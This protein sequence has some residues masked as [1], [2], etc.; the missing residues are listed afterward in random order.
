M[1]S[2]MKSES[3][4]KDGV[5]HIEQ[6]WTLDGNITSCIKDVQEIRLTQ[7]EDSMKFFLQNKLGWTPPK[8]TL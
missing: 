3:S 8:E 2:N 1:I 4:F 7:L 5:L 6:T